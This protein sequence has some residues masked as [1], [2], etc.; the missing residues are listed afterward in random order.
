MHKMDKIMNKYAFETSMQSPNISSSDN[1]KFKHQFGCTILQ[2]YDKI[3]TFLY[4]S[5]P[6][7]LKQNTE[8]ENIL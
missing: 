7:K 5:K 4:G 3:Y 1:A 2:N 8:R 6:V